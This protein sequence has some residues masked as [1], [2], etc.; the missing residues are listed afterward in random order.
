MNL[1]AI[2]P[3]MAPGDAATL[4]L[5]KDDADALELYGLIEAAHDAIDGHN[6]LSAH[7]YCVAENLRCAG[8]AVATD[9]PR[10][11]EWAHPGVEENAAWWAAFE[12]ELAM[13]E[14][15]P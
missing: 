12:A 3:A 11:W 15:T 13:E 4:V 5:A 1:Y 7:V 14:N 9:A 2:L 8:E 10:D 6:S